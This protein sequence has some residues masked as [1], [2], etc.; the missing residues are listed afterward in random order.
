[1][2]FY[3]RLHKEDCQDQHWTNGGIKDNHG[4]VNTTDAFSMCRSNLDSN[5]F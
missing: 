4:G 1:M 3:I 5:L 2:L